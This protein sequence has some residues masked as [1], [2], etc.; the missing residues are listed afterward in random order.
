L[1]NHLVYIYICTYVCVFM[2]FVYLQ[3]TALNEKIKYIKK[4]LQSTL[5]LTHHHTIDELT[6]ELQ[7]AVSRIPFATDERYSMFSNHS[8]LQ[9]RYV[10]DVGYSGNS[11][12]SRNDTKTKVTSIGIIPWRQLFE[13]LKTSSAFQAAGVNVSTLPFTDA[14]RDYARNIAESR[15]WFSTTSQGDL[16]P[17]RTY[18]VLASNRTLLLMNRP[19][20]HRIT[21]GILYEDEHCVMFNTTEEMLSKIVY[22]SSHENERLAIVQRAFEHARKHHYWKSRADTIRFLIDDMNCGI[23][24]VE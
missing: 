9:L 15:M 20:D 24:S 17:L 16:L 7:V 4:G 22:Y 14:V 5:V 10:R 21:D 2:Y 3:Y 12:Y 11:A 19:T 23:N 18:E 8:A 6:S 13:H 1:F